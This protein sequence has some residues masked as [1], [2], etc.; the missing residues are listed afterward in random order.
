MAPDHAEL[1]AKIYNAAWWVRHYRRLGRNNA[2]RQQ[3]VLAL[4]L[5]V[6]HA[7]ACSDDFEPLLTALMDSLEPRENPRV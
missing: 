7:F 2:T 3:A 1:I 6:R 5:A 4:G